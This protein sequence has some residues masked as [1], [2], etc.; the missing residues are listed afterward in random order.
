MMVGSA[1]AEISW[2]KSGRASLAETFLST[3]EGG[4]KAQ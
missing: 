3:R 4:A 2:K 1:Q